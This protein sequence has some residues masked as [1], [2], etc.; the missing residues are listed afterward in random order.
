MHG[1]QV[2]LDLQGL[3]GA[4]STIAV[5]YVASWGLVLTLPAAMSVGRSVRNRIRAKNNAS[6]T[7][8]Q[9]MKA[10]E[11]LRLSIS[12]SVPAWNAVLLLLVP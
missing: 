12:C 1:N 11:K 3:T 10:N 9:G 5:P 8:R 4:L 6:E 7:D 2:A